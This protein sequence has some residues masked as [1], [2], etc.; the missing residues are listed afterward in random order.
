[1]AKMFLLIFTITIIVGSNADSQ[2]E[3]A[4]NFLLIKCGEI[5]HFIEP[6]KTDIKRRRE[7][8][9]DANKGHNLNRECVQAIK[10][11][12]DRINHLLND[13]TLKISELE[14]YVS[15]IRTY[16][17]D[18]KNSHERY[19]KQHKEA[20]LQTIHGKQNEIINKLNFA[21]RLNI[22]FVTDLATPHQQF[23]FIQN[24]YN[25]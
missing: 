4:V 6:V 17:E 23:V 12:N 18:V 25:N 16:V 22:R 9:L 2:V 11:N 5:E 19:V 7:N 3:R 24:C 21:K 8:A 13:K 14:R 20:I 10:E 15:E 1:M